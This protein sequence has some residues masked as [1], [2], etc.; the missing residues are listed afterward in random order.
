MLQ[1]LIYLCPCAKPADYQAP[2]E[3]PP[4][5]TLPP[6]GGEFPP[7]P[8]YQISLSGN[9]TGDSGDDFTTECTELLNDNFQMKAST[10]IPEINSMIG[11]GIC[12]Y[13]DIGSIRIMSVSSSLY[14]TGAA[15]SKI[16]SRM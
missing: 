3:P 4:T 13:A 1:T 14:T 6:P 9:F 10:M 5:T 15:V 11:Q 7:P 8:L 2:T 16:S 12:P